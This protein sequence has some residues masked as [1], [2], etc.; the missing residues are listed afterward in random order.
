MTNEERTLKM[1]SEAM[2]VVAEE[3]HSS[4]STSRRSAPR[5]CYSLSYFVRGNDVS[6]FGVLATPS[7]RRENGVVRCCALG[8]GEGRAWP[9]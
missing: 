1:K 8:T 3:L 7:I 4:S 2:R 5:V 6:I 9:S